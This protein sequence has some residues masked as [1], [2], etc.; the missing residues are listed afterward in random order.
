MNEMNVYFCF[1]RHQWLLRWYSK[2]QI[3]LNIPKNTIYIYIY[4]L[5]TVC[6][7]LVTRYICYY[8]SWKTKPICKCYKYHSHKFDIVYASTETISRKWQCCNIYKNVRDITTFI[9]FSK[10]QLFYTNRNVTIELIRLLE[11]L[12]KENKSN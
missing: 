12:T 2:Y 8:L 6:N 7:K 4:W 9:C 1:E 3:V 5:F 11:F 10:F